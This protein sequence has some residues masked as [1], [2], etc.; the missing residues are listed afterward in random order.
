MKDFVH[1]VFK[2]ADHNRYSVVMTVAVI[3]A[4]TAL[5]ATVG[6]A[7]KTT[8]LR[9]GEKIDK[10]AF[11][12]ETIAVEADLAI[13]QTELEAALAAHNEKVAAH[14]ARVQA[15]LDDLARQDELKARIVNAVGIIA[16]DAME[17]GV[18]PAGLIPLAMGIIGAGAAI[19][20]TADNRRKDAVI[21][22][23]KKD[24]NKA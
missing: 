10:N 9:S 24:N 8:S 13:E 1:R 18:N 20:T 11:H 5:F 17:G 14:N 2:I 21:A 4:L 12:R 3:M 22:S 7:S 15:G 19:G 23:T 6:C 16:S